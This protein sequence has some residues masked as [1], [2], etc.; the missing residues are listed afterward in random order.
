MLPGATVA[1][2]LAVQCQLVA[3]NWRMFGSSSS[4]Q[5]T[6]QSKHPPSLGTTHIPVQLDLIYKVGMTKGLPV[7][8]PSMHTEYPKTHTH[9]QMKTVGLLAIYQQLVGFNAFP[10]PSP[11]S[12]CWEKSDGYLGVIQQTLE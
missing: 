12:L 3:V 9:T 2:H 1:G 10:S 6:S 7:F 5:H 11:H 8:L 4:A